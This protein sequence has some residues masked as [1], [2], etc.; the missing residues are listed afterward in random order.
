[1]LAI[2]H[3]TVGIGCRKYLIMTGNISVNYVE[4]I[5]SAKRRHIAQQDKARSF[6]ASDAVTLGKFDQFDQ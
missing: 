3:G 1:M 2:V 4:F 6:L 5:S